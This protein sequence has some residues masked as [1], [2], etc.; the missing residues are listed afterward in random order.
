M[1]HPRR[2]EDVPVRAFNRVLVAH[3]QGG[4]HASEFAV[5]HPL[6]NGVAHALAQ[7]LHRVR[8]GLRQA[9]RRGVLGAR[10]H[11]TGGLQALLPQPQLVVKPVRVAAAVR[12]FEAHRHLPALAG[13]HL[14]GVAL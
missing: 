9:L 12:G 13:S 4:D 14:A 10:T 6:E 5:F 7:G 2:A 3:H 8:P 11:V 1:R